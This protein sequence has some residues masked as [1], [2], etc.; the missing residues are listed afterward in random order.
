MDSTFKLVSAVN[1]FSC[2]SLIYAVKSYFNW[3]TQPNNPAGA[4]CQKLLIVL[5]RLFATAQQE[6]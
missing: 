5:Q 2:V 4:D 6:R 3:I 1:G